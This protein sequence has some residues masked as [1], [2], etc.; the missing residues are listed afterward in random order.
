MDLICSIYN[1]IQKTILDVERPLVQQ[2]LEAVEGLLKKGREDLNWRSESIKSYIDECMEMVQEVDMIL[3]TI[4]DNVRATDALL[5]NW[6]NNL[7]FDRKDGKTYTFE[8]LN[9]AFNQLIQQRHSEIQDAGKEI[10]KLLSSSNRILKVSKASA[11]WR[12]YVDYFSEIVILGFSKAIMCVRDMIRDWL[13]KFIQ[14][15]TL[16]KRLDIGEGNYTKELEED[17]DVYGAMGQVMEV[18]L[19]NE[20]HCEEFKA[21]FSKYDYL[22]KLD[23]NATLQEFLKAE[24]TQIEGEDTYDDPPLAKFEAQ[25]AKYKQVSAEIANL[26]GNQ[27]IGWVKI[28]AKPL[29]TALT[30]W[31]SKWVYLF[32]HYLQDK[33]INS[34]TGLYSFMEGSNGVL[35]LKVLGE[36]TGA[37][38]DDAA[39]MVEQEEVSEEQKDTEAKEKHKALYDIMSCMRDIRKRE[40][41]TDVMFEPLKEA[42]ALLQAYGINLGE[43]VL[44]Q[45]E[46]GEFSWRALK[47]KMHNRRAQMAALQQTEAFEIRRKSDAFNERVESFRKYFQAT[48]PF[49]AEGGELKSDLVKPAY[50]ILNDFH[51][52][53]PATYPSLIDIVAESK[54]LQEELQYLKSLW[55]MVGTV[56]FT[57]ND[58][59]KTPWDKID[60]EFLVEETKKLS[61]DI[62]TLNKAVR[63]YEV[64]RLLEETLKALLTSLPLVNDLHHPAMRERHWKLL[65]QTTGKQ[66]VMD[67]KFCL[68][69]LLAL[70]LH[71]YVDACSEIVDRAQKE[72][73]IEK[74]IKKIEDTWAGLILAFGVYQDTDISAIQIDDAITEALE[75][76]NLQ[77]QNMSAQKYVQTNPMFLDAVSKWQKN[78]GTVDS[79]LGTWQDVQRKWQALE[80]IFIGSADIRVQLPEDS[81]RFDVVNLDFQA[82]NLEG[83]QERLEN[84]LS[85]L[86]MCEKAL[87][88]YLETKRIAFPRF[89]FVAPAD[90]LDILSKGSNPQLIL[91]HLPKNFDNVHNLTF[92]MDEMGQ[93]TKAAIGMH[94]GEGEFVEF[95]GGECSCDG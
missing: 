2:K 88:D 65:M 23:L 61:K 44:K 64:Y 73:N 81:K 20:T 79:V 69:D 89:Y 41:R 48:A 9:D 51:H 6:E 85:Q 26:P 54:Q 71:N 42:V 3:S 34:I 93:P 62:K 91:R 11:S 49:T 55:D 75:N 59:Y 94:S 27:T 82:C 22:Y 70:E 13:L 30:T 74:Q 86:E 21:Q 37:D 39:E 92:K 53:K 17:Y 36:S 12:A 4:K 52:G 1:R 57:F 60:V 76:D 40:T 16:M 33:V 46:E 63:M 72:L 8:E 31:A 50:V 19:Q 43:A 47:K 90:L 67:D 14:I 18:S 80:S 68:G 35:E 66:F 56:M 77:L 15:G 45:L 7:M 24:G 84:M 5:T 28:N 87:Q 10:G 78:L 38:A 29:R 25:I 83:R 95:F 32:T 58:W